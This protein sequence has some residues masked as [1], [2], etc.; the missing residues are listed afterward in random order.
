M[1]AQ[2]RSID[3]DSNNR[4]SL[5]EYL[6]GYYTID[7]HFLVT[8][9]Q[10]DNSDR[11]AR[12]SRALDAAKLALDVAVQ[13]EQQAA[14]A[15]RHGEVAKA[16]ADEALADLQAREKELADEIAAKDALAND[17]SLGIVKRNRAK[18]EKAQLEAGDSQP[19]R[20]AKILQEA[21]TRKLTKALNR[22][23]QAEAA[24]RAAAQNAQVAFA[25]AEQALNDIIEA[26]GSAEGSLWWLE[27]ELEEAR[28]RMPRHKVKELE[29]RVAAEK[30]KAAAA[31]EVLA[32]VTGG[33]DAAAE[34]VA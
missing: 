3:I 14:E 32:T 20:T 15:R 28:K 5:S 24:A 22:A 17:Q 33:A 23:A 25:D 31:A 7:W 11:V 2:L 9:P 26:G 10:G 30:E 6:I 13:S 19:L 4:I 29:R 21:T 27:R 12:A 8:A 1:R 16:Q 18:A 34:Q